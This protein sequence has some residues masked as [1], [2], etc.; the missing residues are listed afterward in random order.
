[1]ADSI[2]GDTNG[3]V[4]ISTATITIPNDNGEDI[5]AL[6]PVTVLQSGEEVPEGLISTTTADGIIIAYREEDARNAVTAAGVNLTTVLPGM[7]TF[8]GADNTTNQGL[9]D[10]EMIA[11]LDAI[12]ANGVEALAALE[13]NQIVNAGIDGAAYLR[14]YGFSDEQISAMVAR[15]HEL[16]E[17]GVSPAE[18]IATMD[19]EF[20]LPE[21][22]IGPTISP[23]SVPWRLQ[24]SD[25]NYFYVVSSREG[26]TVSIS[27]PDGEDPEIP[28]DPTPE[29]PVTVTITPPGGGEPQIVVVTSP[30]ELAAILQEYTPPANYI[31]QAERFQFEYLTTN[32][33]GDWATLE[34]RLR[35]PMVRETA[36]SFDAN[37]LMF[38]EGYQDELQDIVGQTDK[39]LIAIVSLTSMYTGA[40]EARFV[41]PAPDNTVLETTAQALIT[42][43]I[44]DG[45]LSGEVVE[46]LV[47]GDYTNQE[48]V[49]IL[50]T[51]GILTSNEISPEGYV[52][53]DYNSPAVQSVLLDPER[54]A[55]YSQFDGVNISA[56]GVEYTPELFDLYNQLNTQFQQTAG[57]PGA[58]SEFAIWAAGEALTADI[59]R[60]VREGRLPIETL[61]L[62]F[63]ANGYA[64]TQRGDGS[65]PA[66]GTLCHNPFGEVV[67]G[68]L[69]WSS[70]EELAEARSDIAF[71]L[72]FSAAEG[73][74]GSVYIQQELADGNP[75][76]F[77][78]NQ[79]ELARQEAINQLN[80]ENIVPILGEGG[81]IIGYGVYKDGIPMILADAPAGLQELSGDEL[82]AALADAE[83]R[84]LVAAA[85]MQDWLYSD[86]ALRASAIT[87]DE[88]GVQHVHEVQLRSYE[89]QTR[90]TFDPEGNP[91]GRG[92]VAATIAATTFL[93]SSSPIPAVQ[94][95]VPSVFAGA[96]I[97]EVVAEQ[98]RQASADANAVA[99]NPDLATYVETPTEPS[100][101]QIGQGGG[102]TSVSR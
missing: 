97:P 50:Q 32:L 3:E 9:H 45:S 5:V 62:V 70:P 72:L 23:E 80:P 85:E 6:I 74:F 61:N 100:D 49:D 75:S 57:L 90:E 87:T 91:T 99:T 44:N 79:I 26:G 33:G 19:S 47:N 17:S 12:V 64:N 21:I 31:G 29:D 4:T 92:P 22:A 41:Y 53:W 84:A 82:E 35:N 78:Y 81:L 93:F 66:G 63:S 30:Q 83:Q 67:D 1:M 28:V 14:A 101:R 94:P 52:E 86:Q 55:F 96:V 98:A 89:S 7:I 27:V 25:G 43:L 56:L 16:V 34:A 20:N 8:N 71:A 18:I 59:I 68:E 95:V 48:I 69:A 37:P 40:P 65:L 13:D 77:Y 54:V 2:T 42:K 51:R 73:N 58:E 88:L 76:S 60:E 11:A 36:V 39:S 24:Y 102:N 46:R 10:G 38:R 15:Y